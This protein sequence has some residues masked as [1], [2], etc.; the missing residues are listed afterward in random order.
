MMFMSV[1][2]GHLGCRT[3]VT[4]LP[5]PVPLQ[6]TY[7]TS[8]LQFRQSRS[9][10]ICFKSCNSPALL[11]QHARPLLQ[12]RQHLRRRV[13]PV[14][15]N[16]SSVHS[17]SST[18]GETNQSRSGSLFWARSVWASICRQYQAA[19]ASTRLQ[20]AAIYNPKFLPMVTL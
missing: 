18:D 13:E 7:P 17:N 10:S 9:K 15:A 14:S 6:H 12:H 3:I 19:I 1:G 16:A 5:P 11:Q 20:A 4:L 8:S 2:A